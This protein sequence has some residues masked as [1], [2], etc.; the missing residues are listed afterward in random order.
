M[1]V[2][3][4]QESA[5]KYMKKHNLKNIKRSKLIIPIILTAV[6]IAGAFYEFGN[7]TGKETFH[8]SEDLQIHFIDVGQG[9]S[10]LIITPDG[11]TVLIDCGSKS[12]ESKIISY[13]DSCGVKEITYAVFTHPHEDHI[14]SA[15]AI[16]DKYTVK[17]VLLPDAIHTSTTYENLL[18]AIDREEGIKA[19][20]AFAGGE[21]KIGDLTL[22]VLAPNSNSYENLNNYSIVIRASYGKCSFLFTGDAEAE[23]EAQILK[24]NDGSRLKSDLIKIGHHGSSTSTT[25]GFL[26][27]VSPSI[28]VIMCGKN[29]SYGHPHYQ[30]LSRIEAR[31][32]ALFRTDL[33]GDIVFMTDGESIYN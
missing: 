23:S 24:A 5:G 2:R 9:D 7:F 14:G 17:N 28:A 21:Y 30:V 12:A 13:L 29:N 11:D 27:A 31:N 19:D 8:N 22:D 26:D 10:S 16:F 3:N 1:L 4:I 20:F 25:E 32:I 33:E 6:L 18:K 15:S